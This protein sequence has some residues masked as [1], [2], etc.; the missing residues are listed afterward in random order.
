MMKTGVRRR[1]AR[2]E[3]IL[4]RS[5]ASRK[6]AASEIGAQLNEIEL[7]FIVLVCFRDGNLSD[8]ESVETAL[9]RTLDMKL[10]KLKSADDWAGVRP[11]ILEKLNT[12]VTE[13]GGQ[14]IA[15]N[16]ELILGRSSGL[17]MLG[18]LYAEIP[19]EIKTRYNL[20]PGILFLLVHY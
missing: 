6:S 3:A 18:E 7:A 20:Q 1:L 4:N 8:G 10:A 13:R 2:L 14:P 5:A 19:D 9:G 16:G 15:E 11:L 17:P 12:M